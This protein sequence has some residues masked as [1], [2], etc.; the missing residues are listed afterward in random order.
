MHAVLTYITTLVAS[1]HGAITLIIRARV[2]RVVFTSRRHETMDVS[3]RTV[4]IKNTLFVFWLLRFLL[5]T[6]SSSS[7]V[8]S[9]LFTLLDR[10][11][12]GNSDYWI[13]DNEA[14]SR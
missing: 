4:N 3:V 6:S 13:Q 11:Y 2:S 9:H 1:I 8:F 7:G 10:R 14:V 5:Q 12:K